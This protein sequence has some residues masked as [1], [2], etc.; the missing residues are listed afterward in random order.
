LSLFL[1]RNETGRKKGS[2]LM[3][4]MTI[5]R[6]V[7]IVKPQGFLGSIVNIPPPHPPKKNNQKSSPITIGTLFY[8]IVIYKNLSTRSKILRMLKRNKS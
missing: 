2:F 4:L 6:K 1:E 7:W 5:S 3:C 8:N